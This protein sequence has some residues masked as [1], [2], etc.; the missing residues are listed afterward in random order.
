MTKL[1]DLLRNYLKLIVKNK[2]ALKI[3]TFFPFYL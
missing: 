1:T 2:K 3:E